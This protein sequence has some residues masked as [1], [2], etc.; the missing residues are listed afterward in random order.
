MLLITKGAINYLTVTL[1]E[2]VTIAN[3]YFLFVLAGKSNQPLVKLVLS[4]TSSY[5]DRYNRFSFTE[6]T[7]LTIPNAGDYKYTFYQKETDST[8]ITDDDVV[9][10]TGIARVTAGNATIISHSV[11][12]STVVHED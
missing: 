8:T 1:T 6:G 12:R 11:A 4:D 2:K 7:D 10:E 3:P 5:T 9:L